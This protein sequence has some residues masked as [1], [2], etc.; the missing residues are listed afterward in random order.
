MPNHYHLLVHTPLGNLSR[1]MRHINGVY[2]Q[3]YNRRHRSDGQ[4][5]RGRYKSIL[6]DGDS[7]LL[8]LVRYIHKNP[9]RAGIADRP[10]LYRWSSHAG[11]LSSAKKWDWLHKDFFFSILSP[12]GKARVASYRRF[13]ALEDEEDI[14]RIFSS[15]KW[16]AIIGDQDSVSRMK[17]RFFEERVHPQVPD[18]R[19]PAPETS[20][21]M[22]A[23]CAYY[24]V[25]ETQLLKSRRGWFNEP[26]AVAVYLVRTIRRDSF[27]DI[28]SAFG[29]RGYS[30]V[31]SVLKMIKKQLALDPELN[32]RC[33]HIRNT[34]STAHKET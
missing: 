29:L 31:G 26:R 13:M 28:A 30:S 20:Q 33:K 15:K 34:V 2:T 12:H 24:G 17:A 3:R 7:F 8:R 18:S 14:T 9:V 16:P 10:D 1:R 32:V 23:V 11:Y 19:A 22:Q 25:D 27:P 21:I 4:L 6:V 5:F